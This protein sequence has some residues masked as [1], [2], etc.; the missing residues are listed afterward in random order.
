MRAYKA[1]VRKA[2]ELS[3]R[4]EAASMNT[5][6]RYPERDQIARALPPMQ[7]AINAVR[8]Q[9]CRRCDDGGYDPHPPVPGR[10]ECRHPEV[11]IYDLRTG[12]PWAP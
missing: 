5:P 4:L 10:N 6:R 1:M 9:V 11:P 7:L 2:H 3:I 12:Q 8:V